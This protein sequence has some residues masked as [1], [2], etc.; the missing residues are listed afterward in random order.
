MKHKSMILFLTVAV[1]SSCIYYIPYDESA[2]PPSRPTQPY[3]RDYGYD[4]L[5]NYYD[6]L[7]PYG[8]WVRNPPYGY[9]W[10]PRDVSYK[11]RPYSRGHWAWTDYGWTWMSSERWGWLVFHYGRWGWERNLGW[12]WVPDTV[13][14]PAW[15]AWRW[16][17]LYIGWSPLPPGIEFRP[18]WGLRRRDLN[19]P[20]HYWNFVRGRYFLD[21]SLDR[22]ILPYERNVTIINFTVFNTDISVRNNRTYNE[23]LDIE[24][25]R[26]ATN[27]VVTKYALKDASRPDASRIAGREAIIYK[28]SLSRDEGATPREYVEKEKAVERVEPARLSRISRTSAGDEEAAIRDVHTKESRLLEQTQDEEIR[29]IER[30]SEE[31]K[32]TVR[33]TVERS[34]IE[35]ETKTKVEELKKKHTTEREALKKRQD[36]EKEKVVKGRIKK[37]DKISASVLP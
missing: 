16:G 25:V 34:K 33:T 21:R 32:R 22:L 5:P 18:A 23:G 11:W 19:I 28:P 13:W 12:F 36:E 1:L 7:T 10:I 9:V 31:E 27:Q 8:I 30:K 37:K 6:Y 35:R 4:N 15:V 26:R 2:P 17:D 14:A 29:E 20:S 3:D 24:H